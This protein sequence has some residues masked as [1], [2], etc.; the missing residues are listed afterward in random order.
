MS[1]FGI[2][3]IHR[4]PGAIGEQP[5]SPREN[6]KNARDAAVLDR[7]WTIACRQGDLLL[8]QGRPE[9][10]LLA[11]QQAIDVADTCAAGN[12]GQAKAYLALDRLEDAADS[13]EIALT[14]EPS[15]PEALRLLARIRQ[16]SGAM[17]DALDLLCRARA[18]DPLSPVILLDLGLVFNRCGQTERA[19][20]I[21]REAIELAP[22]DPAP[23]VNLGLMH[24]Q[25]LG[26]PR[27][28]EMFFRAA[29]ECVPYHLAA[30]A[31]LGLALH[32]QE[33]YAE[34]FE[35]YRQALLVHPESKEIR[36]NRAL[37]QLSLGNYCEGW[38]GYELRFSRR[39][40]RNLARFPYP[41]WNGS[42]LP[43]SRLLVLAEQGLGDEIM[44][45]SCI[46]ELRRVTR[47][48]VLECAPRLARLFT[49]SFPEV[50][51]HGRER[52]APLDWID[53]YPDVTVKCAIGSLPRLRRTDFSAFPKRA[54]YLRADPEQ[55]QVYRDRLAQLGAA[56][57]VGLSWRGGTRATR[58]ELRS[59]ELEKLAFLIGLPKVRF[60]CLQH[61]LDAREREQVRRLGMEVW[62]D[63]L[64]DI[65]ETAAVISA[66]DVVISV[67]NA[68]AHLAGA[69]GRPVWI[70]LNS[71]PEWRWLRAGQE[72]PWYPSASLIRPG[73]EGG[74]DKA[75]AIAAARLEE[76]ATGTAKE[77][78]ARLDIG[79]VP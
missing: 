52:H 74:A 12:L 10:A 63:V 61:G 48:I 77:R 14:I 76:I 41:D 22:L 27:S 69:L 4:R 6:S 1:L 44:F 38:Q 40:G 15:S 66:L 45:A 47:G 11:Y 75:L 71:S 29:L 2:L 53:A 42:D 67:A 13:L 21:Y 7:D 24:L 49:R 60:V 43:D 59:I 23:R 25:Q 20:E 17:D 73:L 3:G 37:A 64:S 51:V 58:G 28:A 16:L 55:T 35:V 54:G 33:R 78:A 36:W 65:D 8:D 68:N 62:E 19:M 30:L 32:D 9:D 5:H 72:L 50:A 31:N 46:P 70:L 39:G 79:A 34:E 57:T 26:D 18:I 56:V